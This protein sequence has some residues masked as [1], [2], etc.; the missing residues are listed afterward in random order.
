MQHHATVANC[1]A[2]AARTLL[3]DKPIFDSKNIVRE[4]FVVER[5]GRTFHRIVCIRRSES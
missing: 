5:D 3:A 1:P 2:E 4:L